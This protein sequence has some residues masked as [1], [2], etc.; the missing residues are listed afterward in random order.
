MIASVALTQEDSN[1]LCENLRR[2]ESLARSAS[3]ARDSRLMS[4]IYSKIWI[5][6]I[7]KKVA[8]V[9]LAQIETECLTDSSDKKMTSKTTS[10]HIIR[11]RLGQVTWQ[12]RNFFWVFLFRCRYVIDLI[13]WI[14]KALHKVFSAFCNDAPGSYTRKTEFPLPPIIFFAFVFT[15]RYWVKN[16]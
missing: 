15:C 13:Y 16:H 5:I 2:T 11:P 8:H 14:R 7:R 1:S 12:L 6:R 3:D 10:T 4:M 9:Y